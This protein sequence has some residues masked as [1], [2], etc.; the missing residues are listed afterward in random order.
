[1]DTK[2]CESKFSS[3]TKFS[4]K[5]TVGDSSF[6]IHAYLGLHCH[7]IIA[8]RSPKRSAASEKYGESEISISSLQV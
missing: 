7:L 8:T 1:M 5:L 4:K 2:T 6:I 3:K